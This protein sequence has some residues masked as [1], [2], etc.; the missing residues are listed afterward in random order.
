MRENR[1]MCFHLLCSETDWRQVCMVSSG[2]LVPVERL[3]AKARICRNGP[4]PLQ[5]F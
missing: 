1:I 3:T 2:S 5:S 4:T